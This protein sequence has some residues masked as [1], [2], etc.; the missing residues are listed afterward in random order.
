MAH[1]IA[2]LPVE[3][4]DLVRLR[5]GLFASY[6]PHV[7][8]AIREDEVRARRAFLGAAMAAGPPAIH[9]VYRQGS[10]LEQ[11]VRR[12]LAHR[13]KLHHPPG[14]RC[15]E[16]ERAQRSIIFSAFCRLL[17]MRLKEWPSMPISSLRRTNSGTLK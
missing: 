9:I 5:D 7:H 4:E 17:R 2:F 16:I 13:R 3:E 10:R 11:G 6:M 14:R 8:A 15:Q 1:A 12:D